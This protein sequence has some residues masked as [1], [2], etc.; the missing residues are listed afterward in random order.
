NPLSFYI[1]PKSTIEPGTSLILEIRMLRGSDPKLWLGYGNED[2]A[3]EPRFVELSENAQ[4]TSA[5][6]SVHLIAPSSKFFIVGSVDAPIRW[7]PKVFLWDAVNFEHSVASFERLGGALLASFLVLAAFSGIV[8]I[9]N[10]DTTYLLFAGWL[11]TSLRVAAINGG[12]DL[13]WLGIHLAPLDNLIFI[14]ATLA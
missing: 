11:I 13:N 2:G 14:R 6:L 12:W 4:P 1:E 3:G 5:G 8:A 9:L 10:R 7:M